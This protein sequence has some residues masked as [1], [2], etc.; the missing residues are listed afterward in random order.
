M[1]VGTDGV[2]LGAWTDVEHASRT[3]DIGTGTGLLALM[4]AQRSSAVY[5]DAIEIEEKSASQA[6][7]NFASSR[8][9]D[10]IRSL[11]V[12][13]DD[14]CKKIDKPL[15]DLIIC[16]PPYFSSSLK[17]GI[18][19]AIFFSSNIGYTLLY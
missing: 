17:A 4:L 1:K 19:T 12:S 9:S 13:F 16:N 14:Y 15:Y 2:I 3:L 7:L 11:E 10:R 5:V 18:S 6:A 8:F